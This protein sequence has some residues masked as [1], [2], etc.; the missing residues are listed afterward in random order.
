MK[1][2]KAASVR[3]DGRKQLVV[4]LT[5]SIIDSIKKIAIDDGKHTYEV[6][7]QALENYIKA[8]I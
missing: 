8:R 1:T 2:S 4:M 3:K 5:P 6:V 7:E